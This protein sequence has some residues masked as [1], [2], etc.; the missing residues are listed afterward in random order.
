MGFFSCPVGYSP[1]AGPRKLE[2]GDERGTKESESA[3]IILVPSSKAPQSLLEESSSMEI[4]V[5]LVWG[6]PPTVHLLVL[7]L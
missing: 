2:L 4:E 1:D 5:R 3:S 6:W 7:A